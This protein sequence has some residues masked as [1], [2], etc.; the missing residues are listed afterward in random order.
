MIGNGIL[1]DSVEGFSA[2]FR[3][4]AISSS[5][6][7]EDNLVKDI[8]RPSVVKQDDTGRTCYRHPPANL[9]SGIG[10]RNPYNMKKRLSIG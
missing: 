5:A 8:I 4:G 2:I 7:N 6:T 10:R 1:E 9:K 3:L